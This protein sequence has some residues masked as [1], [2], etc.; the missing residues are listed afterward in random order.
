VGK[1]DKPPPQDGWASENEYAASSAFEDDGLP[2]RQ[3]TLTLR[4]P[5]LTQ[6]GEEA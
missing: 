2:Q 6:T 3:I 5:P 1:S 4:I